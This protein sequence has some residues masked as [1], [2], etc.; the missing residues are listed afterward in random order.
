MDVILISPRGHGGRLRECL[1]WLQH[2]PNRDLRVVDD[3]VD[4]EGLHR[5]H[6]TLNDT[7]TTEAPHGTD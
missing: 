5:C 7:H 2:L 4:R 3:Y 1:D 6:I